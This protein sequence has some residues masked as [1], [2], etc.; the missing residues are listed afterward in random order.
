[1]NDTPPFNPSSWLD[2]KQPNQSDDTSAPPANLSPAATASEPQTA[3]PLHSNS[4][5]APATPRRSKGLLFSIF[6]LIVIAAGAALTWYQSPTQ[7]L[8]R[9]LTYGVQGIDQFSY[10]SE[11][12]ISVD[13][14]KMQ[15]EAL[16]A[17][18]ALGQPGQEPSA[19][20]TFEGTLTV[21]GEVDAKDEKDVR[22]HTLVGLVYNSSKADFELT[23]IGDTL[24]LKV[25]SLPDLGFFNTKPLLG[26]W[27]KIE[28]AELAKQ[29]GFEED[30]AQYKD[31]SDLTDDQIK[32]LEALVKQYQILRV[33]KSF[34]ITKVDSSFTHHYALSLDPEALV[35]LV[36]AAAPIVSKDPIPAEQLTQFEE[37]ASFYKATSIEA[38]V[39]WVSSQPRKAVI[40]LPL[41]TE[42]S[43]QFG[44]VTS[45]IFL[46]SIGKKPAIEAPQGSVPIQQIIEEFMAGQQPAATQD[47]QLDLLAE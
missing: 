25:S 5:I 33:A 15:A 16:A 29:Y 12:T 7:V 14:T 22:T 46:N 17:A 28:P 30:F 44:T 18:V 13:P 26:Q 40:A 35:G 9:V 2:P 42:K 43:V 31:E 20:T 23:T 24:Y 6:A 19:P 21:S 36:K 10:S 41:Q 37:M 8:E 34:P 3:S 38:W 27:M 32:Q 11:T 39:D 4:P 45:T 47:A 1:M